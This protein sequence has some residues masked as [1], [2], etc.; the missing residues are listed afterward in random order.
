MHYS[1]IPL[2]IVLTLIDCESR[3]VI[4]RLLFL[5]MTIE[6]REKKKKNTSCNEELSFEFGLLHWLDEEDISKF[7]F[8]MAALKLSGRV[9]MNYG[10]VVRGSHC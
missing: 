5:Q 10:C 1:E 6:W 4:N 7:T 3:K 2:N 8:C 9:F